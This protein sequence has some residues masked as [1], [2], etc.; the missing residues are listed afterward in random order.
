MKREEEG[1]MLKRAVGWTNVEIGFAEKD[2]TCPARHDN[3]GFKKLFHF[4]STNSY[5]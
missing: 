2:G 4:P 5:Y 3:E 1:G